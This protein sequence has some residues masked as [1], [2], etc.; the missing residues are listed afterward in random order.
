MDYGAKGDAVTDDSMVVLP[1]SLV[2]EKLIFRKSLV[3]NMFW[4]I[5]FQLIMWWLKKSFIFSFSYMTFLMIHMTYLNNSHDFVL[6]I[7]T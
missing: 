6:W 1:Y 7:D 3:L 2:D 5:I 4:A